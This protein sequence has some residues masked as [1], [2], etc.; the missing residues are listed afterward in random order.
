M[1][2]KSTLNVALLKKVKQH[3]LDN[4]ARL[5]MS[6]WIIN[7]KIAAESTYCKV[8]KH[9]FNFEIKAWD[10]KSQPIPPCG[11]IGCIAGWTKIIGDNLDP[12]SPDLIGSYQRRAAEL[13]G[14]TENEASD[15]FFC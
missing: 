11:T 10:A 13:L 4:P 9:K 1:K 6:N 3:I 8:S 12:E 7:R 15:L 5:R 2:K 14:I